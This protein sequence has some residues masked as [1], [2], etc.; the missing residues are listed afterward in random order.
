MSD[1]TKSVR[2]CKSWKDEI[3]NRLTMVWARFEREK[4]LQLNGLNLFF[5]NEVIWIS[6]ST[7]CSTQDEI[8]RTQPNPATRRNIDVVA[9]NRFS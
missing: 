6:F 4:P 5:R 9:S 2:G 3:Q 7:G 8:V 1:G